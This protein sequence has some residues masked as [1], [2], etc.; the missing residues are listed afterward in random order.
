MPQ[1][2]RK[3]PA[4]N[5]LRGTFAFCMRLNLGDISI[6][7]CISSL[8]MRLWPFSSVVR[9]RDALRLYCGSMNWYFPFPKVWVMSFADFSFR[10][11]SL[12]GVAVIPVAAIMS[13][14]AKAIL[15]PKRKNSLQIWALVFG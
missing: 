7:S 5:G 14:R 1:S 10:N 3:C 12:A 4:R 9:M 13:L 15:N 2:A 8:S 6:D 11:S